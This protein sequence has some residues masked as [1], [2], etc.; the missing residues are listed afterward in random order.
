MAF[1]FYVYAFSAVSS[2]AG[3]A[4]PIC[5]SRQI[6]TA[7]VGD[8]A[9]LSCHFSYGKFM[10][11]LT[12]I[13]KKI[14]EGTEAIVVYDKGK[15]FSNLS[16]DCLHRTAMHKE[17]FLCKD[18]TL[19]VTRIRPED[20]GEYG[21]W[22]VLSPPGRVTEHKCCTRRLYVTQEKGD[23]VQLVVAWS[24]YLS[25]LSL[26]LLFLFGCSKKKPRLDRLND[27]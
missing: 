11:N 7:S 1:L 24:V 17:W 20:A 3:S 12:V 4:I 6:V 8:S 21:C 13:W 10:N 26:L 5:S 18:A 2:T 16:A 14:T 23:T 25:F 27:I 9:V 19:T 22:M 15:T